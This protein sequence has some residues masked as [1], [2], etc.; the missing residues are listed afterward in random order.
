MLHTVSAQLERKQA[1]E[2]QILRALN[3]ETQVRYY[4]A[5]LYIYSFIYRSIYRLFSLSL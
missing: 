2:D 1:I 5:S 4:I 3:S